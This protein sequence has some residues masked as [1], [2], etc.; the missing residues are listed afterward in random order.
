MSKKTKR[1]NK[2][3][4]GP[5][6]VTLSNLFLGFFAIVMI[7]RGHFATACWLIWIASILDMFDGALARLVKSSSPFGA[8]IDSL[9]DITSFGIAPSYLIYRAVF[10][11]LGTIGLLFAF[12][13]LLAG[14]LRL[15][16]FHVVGKV[17]DRRK[18]V[19]LPIPTSALLL[20][21]CYLYTRVGYDYR[22]DIRVWLSLV[23]IVSLLMVS[24]IPY[25]KAYNLITKMIRQPFTGLPVLV[26]G[27]VGMVW[28]PSRAL[29]PL[30]IFYTLIG[31]VEWGLDHLRRLRTSQEDEENMPKTSSQDEYGGEL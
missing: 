14:A 29:F 24:P 15:A 12:M 5:N 20:A 17:K 10:E 6:L 2:R 27:V 16:R 8:Q 7:G 23:P 11:P 26:A 3:A 30:M 18:F 22:V 28:T 19:G 21:G 9:S 31:P 4:L 1:M 13:P 25:W